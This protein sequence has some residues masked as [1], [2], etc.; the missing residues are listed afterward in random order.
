[1]PNQ[2]R[3]S[4]TI[5]VLWLVALVS[6]GLNVA[7]INTLLTVRRQ[8]AHGFAGAADVVAQL[9]IASV[10][11]DVPVDE[12]VPVDSNVPLDFS[13]QVP[14][15][16][17]LP[18][19]TVINTS[20]RVLGVPVPVSAPISITVPISF[21]VDVPVQYDVKFNTDVPVKFSVPIEIKIADTPLAKSLD[22]FEAMLRGL[23]GQ[24]GGAP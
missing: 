6:L 24:L 16:Q 15:S 20:I 8:A 17:T 23:S 11:Y 10:K 9:K 4:W 13:V 19:K 1:M 5:Y 7:V 22:D 2:S 12:H 14:I 18:I 21:T 3:R